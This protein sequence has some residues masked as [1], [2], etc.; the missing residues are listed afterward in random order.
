MDYDFQI[1]ILLLSATH[2]RNSHSNSNARGNVHTR[3]WVA[4][5]LFAFLPV[6]DMANTQINFRK[7]PSLPVHT[8]LE[9]HSLPLHF[10]TQFLGLPIESLYLPQFL[11]IQKLCRYHL[12]SCCWFFQSGSA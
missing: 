3:S 10:H 9:I 12:K 11:Q 7:D 1:D 6:R 8:H 2:F 4:Y 5:K